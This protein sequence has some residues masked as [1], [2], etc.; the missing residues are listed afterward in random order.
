MAAADFE[1]VSTI[2][3]KGQT[4]VPKAVRDALRVGTGDKIAFRVDSEGV[5]VR[6]ADE[7][8]DDPAMG[9]FLAFVA[10][11][12]ERHPENLKAFPEALMRR[13]AELIRDVEVDPDA[14]ID[15]DVDL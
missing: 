6:R 12:I 8:R 11:D 1:E 15:G 14:A 13:I 9:S 4:T 7:A 10:R 5:T 3:A 2:T